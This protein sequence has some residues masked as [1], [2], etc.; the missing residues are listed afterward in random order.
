MMLL[1]E[2]LRTIVRKKCMYVKS[3]KCHTY[4]IYKKYKVQINS[5]L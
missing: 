3:A 2:K 5:I 1:Q 4:I